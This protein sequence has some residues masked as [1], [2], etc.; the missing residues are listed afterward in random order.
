MNIV[1]PQ[2]SDWQLVLPL[3]WSVEKMVPLLVDRSD[4]LELRLDLRS[5]G[6]LVLV[7]DRVPENGEHEVSKLLS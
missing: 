7:P 4:P 2:W 1:P 6:P 5:V 3:E